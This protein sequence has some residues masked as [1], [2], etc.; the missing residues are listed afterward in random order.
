MTANHDAIKAL[1]NA[2][3]L[4]C[5]NILFQDDPFMGTAILSENQQYTVDQKHTALLMPTVYKP[6]TSDLAVIFLDKTDKHFHE[7]RH[8]LTDPCR[9]TGIKEEN[10]DKVTIPEGCEKVIT[11]TAKDGEIW[12]LYRGQ[13][14]RLLSHNLPADQQNFT[15]NFFFLTPEGLRKTIDN[16]IVRAQTDLESL[17]ESMSVENVHRVQN[18]L[19]KLAELPDD[20]LT[21]D[22]RVLRAVLSSDPDYL[23]RVKK[24]LEEAQGLLSPEALEAASA[25]MAAQDGRGGAGS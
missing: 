14:E 2:E 12:H 5:F 4:R 25:K 20:L 22:L 16:Q 23:N 24:L 9:V 17:R 19:E 6:V 8:N 10:L 13:N 7:L 21:E 11:I 3:L 15:K 18:R 1:S